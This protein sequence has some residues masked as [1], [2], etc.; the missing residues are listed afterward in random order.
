M[1]A[2]A[3]HDSD[4]PTPL[5][6]VCA[7]A[8]CTVADQLDDGEARPRPQPRR[9][10]PPTPAQADGFAYDRDLPPS[11]PPGE[12]LHHT[13][14][15]AA[16]PPPRRRIARALRRGARRLDRTLLDRRLVPLD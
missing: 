7:R 6:R 15:P 2:D 11:I 12:R 13:H 8:L 10:A 9:P 1:G 4:A 16:A 14:D 5:R 3:D